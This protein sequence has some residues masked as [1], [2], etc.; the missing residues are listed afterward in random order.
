MIKKIFLLLFAI[1]I[2]IQIPSC[3]DEPNT[4]GIG[5]LDPDFIVLDTLNTTID[6][7]AQTSS[8][9]KTVVSLG[10]SDNLLVGKK[11]N[12]EASFLIKF[13]LGLTDSLKTD[14]NSG[15]TTITEAKVKL[16]NTYQWGDST[17]AFNLTAHN[18]TSNWSSI[19]FTSD[20]LH[21]ASFNYDATNSASLL[22]LADSVKT[23]NLDPN[24]IKTW[25][26]SV[27]DTSLKTNKG[28]YVKSASSDKVLGFQ[29]K[30]SFLVNQPELQVVIKKAGV[31]TDTLTYFP[32]GDVSVV[33]GPLPTIG[34]TDI[35]VQSGLVIN[36]KVWFDVSSIPSGSIIN[37]AKL[38]L[39]TDTL[40]TIKGTNIVDAILVSN[41]VDSTNKII[42]ST[43][44]QEN[45]FP[46]G[47]GYE[48]LVTTFVQSWIGNGKNEGLLLSPSVGIDGVD[49][50][51]LKGSG[52][53]V[54]ADRP[55]LEIIYTTRK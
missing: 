53:T 4:F 8:T 43:I 24:L 5:L 6:S 55:R 19:G 48:G 38:F 1:I 15:A 50:F 14:I 41:I 2:I 13:V 17:A 21:S 34:A 16:I 11:D 10:A 20:S 26:Q 45:L 27:I 12:I 9:F 22:N 51:V 32:E 52:T 54:F 49:L 7:V 3:S 29:A 40:L 37:R 23:F 31:Y 25:L 42:D 18:V 46:S 36:S 33:D 30:T 39:K 35:A 47:I 28:L 44:S